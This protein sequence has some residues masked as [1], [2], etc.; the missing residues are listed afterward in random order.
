LN[1]ATHT[2]L[3][4][5]FNGI[6]MKTLAHLVQCSQAKTV[7]DPSGENLVTDENFE[8]LRGIPILLFSGKEIVV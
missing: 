3:H 1:E 4:R 2:Q 5:F 8:Q 7:V 6:G